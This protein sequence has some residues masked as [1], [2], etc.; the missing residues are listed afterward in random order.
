MYMHQD[1]GTKIF[2]AVLFINKRLGITKLCIKN[3]M[4]KMHCGIF[5]Q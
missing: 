2:L 3:R 4:E 5:I 1:I